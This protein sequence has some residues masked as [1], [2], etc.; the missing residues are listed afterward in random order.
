MRND[1]QILKME[2]RGLGRMREDTTSKPAKGFTDAP[3]D[4]VS[5]PGG[6]WGESWTANSGDWLEICT[7]KSQTFCI[8]SPQATQPGKVQERRSQRKTSEGRLGGS[9]G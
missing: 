1:N 8:P 2:I 3:Q 5:G 4:P 9:A 7:W 6:R